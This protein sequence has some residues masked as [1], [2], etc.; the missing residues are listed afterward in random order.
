LQSNAITNISFSFWKLRSK[1]SWLFVWAIS[2]E[3]MIFL[4]YKKSQ[5]LLLLHLLFEEIDH[6][7]RRFRLSGFRC[8]PFGLLVLRK[9]QRVSLRAEF[10]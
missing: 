8:R 7:T 5:S 9:L 3:S 6:V 4:L 10:F 1:F 2:F